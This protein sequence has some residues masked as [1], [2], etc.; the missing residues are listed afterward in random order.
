[1]V[2]VR[3]YSQPFAGKAYWRIYGEFQS[4]ASYHRP[5]SWYVRVLR[6]AGLVLT[7]LEETAPTPEFATDEPQWSRRM[8]EVPMHILIEA[9]KI[10]L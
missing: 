9:P 6:S 10:P 4:A 7:A 3:R 5:F 8:T 2:K 1:M